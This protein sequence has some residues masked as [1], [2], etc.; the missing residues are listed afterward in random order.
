[1]AHD[2]NMLVLDF[3]TRSLADLKVCGTD[4][5]ASDL[6]TQIL[7]CA[8]AFSN[9][10]IDASEWLWYG[11]NAVSAHLIATIE[12]HRDSGGL[13]AAHNARFDQLI[14]EL[15]G[16]PDH[17][18]P[19]I[20]ADQWYCTSA[21]ARVNAL[22]ASLDDATR[23]LNAKH[24]KNPAGEALIRKLCIPIKGT[25]NFYENILD[26]HALGEYCLDDV[27]ATIDLINRCRLMS[28]IEHADWLANERINDKGIRID[29]PLAEAATRYA[30]VETRAIG[31]ELAQ[32]TGG[33]VTKHTQNARIKDWLIPRLAPDALELTT[34]YKDSVK[35][36][37]LAKDIRTDMLGRADSGEIE[38]A[39]DVYNVI[40]ALDDGNKSSVS[41]FKRMVERADEDGDRVRGAF[42]YAGAATLRYTSRG[43]QLH[44]FRRDCWK[45]DE[46]E[47]LR[48]MMLTGHQLD[49]GA[50][51][52]TLSK[53]LRPSLIP[54]EGN[55]YIVA[56]W[57][58]VE[59]MAMPWLTDDPRAE[60]E[61]AMFRRGEDP[62]IKAA[63]DAGTDIRQVGKVIKLSL[64]YGGS[65]G[66]FNA[67]G[68][69]Y[70]VFLPEYE[71]KGIV[72]RYRAANP[73]AESFWNKLETAATAAVRF[74]LE[75]FTAGRI[76]YTFVP[77]LMN[78]SLL[79]ELPSGDFITYPD[80]RLEV[81]ETEFGIKRQLS[82]LKANFK[83]KAGDKEWPRFR[84]WRGLLAENVTQA[85][86][87]A[88]LR[89]QV[90]KFTDSAV[91]HCH[92]EL[93]LEVPEHEAE[94]RRDEL[95]RSMET[96]PPWAE[97]LPLAVTIDIVKRYG[98]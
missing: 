54:A 76:K 33:V 28:P 36:H 94:Q 19:E 57:K 12:A 25:T 7:C 37:S 46:M 56:D 17:G 60:P 2:V 42:M 34:V 85:F 75:T 4:L 14:W 84:L 93:G 20:P 87:A 13:F 88:L 22:P 48:S 23:A 30:D 35:K 65:V 55:V 38:L 69:N 64:G 39:D 96:P 72:K 66:A 81:V 3:E 70:G 91:L 98:K 21:Q 90:R 49:E 95:K 10:D 63:H 11:S 9:A 44:N 8:F 89:Y 77:S 80:T 50:V 43:L 6:S 15:I 24:R 5:Y 1:V 45:P 79:C 31:K 61:L 59:N 26:L 68:R 71:V 92:D 73:W 53:S 82:A 18:L 16:V 62:Y 97:G 52:D 32:L 78:G 51:M 40:A 58:S 83:P 67:M 41:K 47:T 27:L 29:R 74:P 86:C